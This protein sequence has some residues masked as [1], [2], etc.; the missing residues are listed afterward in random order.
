MLRLVQN[1]NARNA[2]N[3]A[4]ERSNSEQRRSEEN[5][6]EVTTMKGKIKRGFLYLMIG[7][8]VMFLSRLTYSFLSTAEQNALSRGDILNRTAISSALITSVGGREGQ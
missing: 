8:V 1:D 4:V 3:R 7:F 2:T 5:S 6:Q